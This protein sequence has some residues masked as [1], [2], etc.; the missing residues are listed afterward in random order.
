MVL[1]NGKQ[2]KI[3]T[4]RGLE[5]WEYALAS[6]FG[7]GEIRSI[8]IA[9]I[10]LSF[11]WT[12]Q[13]IIGVFKG[14]ATLDFVIAGFIATATGFILHEMGHKFVAIRRGYVANFRL[15]TWG[16]LL[17]IGT[18][19]ASGGNFLFGAPGAV[20]IAPAASN[21]GYGYGSSYPSSDPDYENMI[22]SAAGPGL[23]LLFALGFLGLLL[24]SSGFLFIVGFLGY[25]LNIGLGSFNMLPVPPLDGS[26]IFRRSIPVALAIALP[27]WG[28]FALFAL[29][30]FP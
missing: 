30:I 11:G 4:V 2:V 19:V 1:D 7:P 21:Y 14:E 20:Y 24:V 6:Q 22:I 12:Y 27:L 29:Q 15:W 9:W 25:E 18:V 26:K 3:G 10:V 13:S 23:N 17:T 28:L 16:L 5:V 8:I